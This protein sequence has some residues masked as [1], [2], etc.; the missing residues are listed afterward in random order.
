MQIKVFSSKQVGGQ[1]ETANSNSLSPAECEQARTSLQALLPTKVFPDELS[2]A[3]F[4]R[5]D[6]WGINARFL[7]IGATED[8]Q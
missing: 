1:N 2:H 6:V 5:R 7:S 8:L 4:V 3:W